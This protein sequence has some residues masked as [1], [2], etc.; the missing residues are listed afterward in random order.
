MGKVIDRKNFVSGDYIKTYEDIDG[1]LVIEELLLF[2]GEKICENG[3]CVSLKMLD[4]MALISY[5][6]KVNATNRLY[7]GIFLDKFYHRNGLVLSGGKI[8]VP[9]GIYEK[10]KAINSQYKIQNQ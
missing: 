6:L 3:M 9:K 1:L 7:V 10:V 5:N 8:R 2:K 4:D